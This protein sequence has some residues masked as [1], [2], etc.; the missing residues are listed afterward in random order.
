MPQLVQ[1]P[2]PVPPT[3]DDPYEHRRY[4]RERL[5]AGFRV[6]A[7]LGFDEGVMGHLSARDPLEPDHFWVNPFAVP[8][9]TITAGDL[10]LVSSSGELVEGSGT[11][12]PGAM[13][14][15][16]D[17]YAAH[18]S[19]QSVG[20]THSIYGRAWSTLRRPLDPITNES[21]VFF[22]RLG[23]FD[24]H[25]H[26]EG[27]ELAAAVQPNDRALIMLNHGIVA[28]GQTVDEMLYYFMSLEKCCQVQ[29]AAESAG[30][31]Q[32]LADDVAEKI[33]GH[34]TPERAWLNFQPTYQTVVAEQPDLLS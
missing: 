5:A 34:M 22:R 1:A 13:I 27:A 15:H 30:T 28:L 26:G 12:H 3:F 11:V 24:T 7:K 17:I 25:A 23:L 21:A 18:P 9:A 19:I 20:H 10:Q 31:P 33:A 16:P 14:L 2:R 29:I 8:F 32:S 4:L 6:F